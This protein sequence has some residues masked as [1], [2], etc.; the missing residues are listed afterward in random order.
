MDEWVGELQAGRIDRAWFT[1]TLVPAT[2]SPG[3]IEGAWGCCGHI[4]GR[5][6]AN[7]TD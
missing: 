5:F 7:R 6:T 3:L 2:L 4:S 1:L